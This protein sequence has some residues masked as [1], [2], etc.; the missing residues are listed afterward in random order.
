MERLPLKRSIHQVYSG[1]NSSKIPRTNQK[2]IRTK[3]R[4]QDSGGESI[5]KNHLTEQKNMQIE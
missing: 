3:D 4:I 5:S 2:R 1:I